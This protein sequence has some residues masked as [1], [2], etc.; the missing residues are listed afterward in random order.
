MM[1]KNILF[2]EEFLFS[3]HECMQKIYYWMQQLVLFLSR[4]WIFEVFFFAGWIKFSSWQTTLMLFE[5]EYSVAVL[6]PKIA[7]YFATSAEL[8][9]PSLLL[10]GIVPRFS[11]LSLFFLNL[12]AAISYPD[13]S[14]AGIQQHIVWG[15]LLMLVFIFGSGEIQ[16]KKLW[17]YYSL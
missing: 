7:A 14:A 12:V 6:S 8:I 9:F 10:L 3:K 17:D 11:A 5:Y 15:V 2:F 13:I 16:V 4:I 1:L